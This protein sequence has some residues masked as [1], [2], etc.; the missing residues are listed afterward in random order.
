[1]K[2][3]LSILIVCLA[4]HFTANAQSARFGITAGATFAN[5]NVNVTGGS[6]TEKTRM[7]ITF[8]VLGD[9]P[10]GKNFSFQPAINYVQKG[11][12][13]DTTEDGSTINAQT[14][15]NSIEVPLNLV[16]N[17]RS[18]SGNFFI[19]AGPS[20]AYAISGKY[21]L[22]D[23][24][25]SISSDA[26]FGNTADDDLR[27]MDIGANFVAGYCFNNGLMLS[28]NYN[29]GFSNLMPVASEGSIK[30]H[31]FGIK[32]GFLFR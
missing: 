15:V 6:I 27:S 17:A 25:N 20:F 29:T 16:F 10:L 7:G 1:M 19:G 22:T 28:A 11:A 5:Y 14:I 26:K 4:L 32:A 24:T 2:K 30:S 21:K 9:I 23:G 13:N 8:G 12:K 18:T 31:Y 3:L